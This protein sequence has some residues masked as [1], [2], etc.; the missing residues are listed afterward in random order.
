M[1]SVTCKINSPAIGPIAACAVFLTS[2]CSRKQGM[3]T[4]VENQNK[5]YFYNSS[6]RQHCTL[7][8]DTN[9]CVL[10]PPHYH[11]NTIIDAISRPDKTIYN[12]NNTTVS[13]CKDNT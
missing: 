9:T 2:L 4:R 8:F 11:F 6:L 5:N 10:P 7:F 1:I 13:K 3:A 12:S